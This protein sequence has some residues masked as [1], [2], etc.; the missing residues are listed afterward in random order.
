VHPLIIKSNE[1]FLTLPEFAEKLEKL[2]TILKTGDVI[3]LKNFF[4]ELEL[5]YTPDQKIVDWIHLA[6]KSGLNGEY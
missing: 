5:G 2:H 3:S 1:E 6:R 4:Q